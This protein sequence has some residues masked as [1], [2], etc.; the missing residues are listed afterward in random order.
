MVKYVVESKI[1]SSY[2]ARNK[3]I[4]ITKGKII[5]FIDSDCIAEKKWLKNGILYFTDEYIAAVAGQI[6][7]SYKEKTPNFW[8]YYDSARK[9]N[10][11][12]YVMNAGFGATANL[13]IRK[14]IFD[15]Y[16]LFR[17]DLISGGD[18]EFGWR[19]TKNSEKIVYGE[20]V[21]VFHKA[22]SNFKYIMTKSRRIANGQ[23]CLKKLNLLEHGVITWRSFLPAKFAP[24][25]KGY[26]INLF[27]KVSFIMV[28]NIFNYYNIFK[29]LF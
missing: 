8:E 23:K 18:Y 29:R 17:D 20:N 25:L 19:I 3:A 27:K 12:V 28:K 11:K 5:A 24:D 15:K 14:K 6:K 21:V 7:F 26:N 4:K 2:A 22:R 1:Q 9:L 13:F 16:G 10:Q